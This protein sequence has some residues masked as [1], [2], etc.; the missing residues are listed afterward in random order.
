MGMLFLDHRAIF[1]RIA[2]YL[3]LVL[4]KLIPSGFR[5]EYWNMPSFLLFSFVRAFA[6]FFNDWT[7]FY[8]LVSFILD[9]GFGPH[10]IKLIF[11]EG[12][13]SSRGK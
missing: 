5:L 2:K 8:F 6:S 11:A 1:A 13:C 10:F 3:A 12:K 4:S 7:D 9:K